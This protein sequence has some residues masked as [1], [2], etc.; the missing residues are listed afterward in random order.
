[1]TPSRADKLVLVA[2]DYSQAG[3]QREVNEDYM[4]TPEGVDPALVAR[5]AISM[6]SQTA[7][8]AMPPASKPVHWQ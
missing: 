6:W 1:M 7:W 2:A 3:L 5:Q 8:A 4:A